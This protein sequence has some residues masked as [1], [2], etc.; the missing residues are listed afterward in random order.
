MSQKYGYYLRPRTSGVPIYQAVSVTKSISFDEFLDFCPSSLTRAKTKSEAIHSVF[1]ALEETRLARTDSTHPFPS[2]STKIQKRPLA[3]SPKNMASRHDDRI[4]VN[5]TETSD[6]VQH[7]PATP[8]RGDSP[9]EIQMRR[10][11]R[12]RNLQKGKHWT[13]LSWRL[14]GYRITMFSM[15]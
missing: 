8:L 4:P 14:C 5:S 2:R 6:Q 13:S 10:R 15:F 9:L 11:P 7:R 1:K 3:A 12:T